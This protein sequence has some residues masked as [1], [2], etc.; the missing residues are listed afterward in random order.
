METLTYKLKYDALDIKTYFDTHNICFFDIETTGFNR[1]KDI[2]YLV[3]LLIYNGKDYI[4]K[5]YLLEEVDEEKILLNCLIKDFN[6]CECLI[7]FNGDSFDI[8]FLDSKYKNHHIDYKIPIEKSFDIYKIIKSNKYL[9]DLK[10]FKL[11]SIEKYLGINRK[12]T[13]SGKECIDLFYDYLDNKNDKSKKLILQHNYDDLYYL[14]YVLKIL[15]IIEYKKTIVLSSNSSNKIKLKI[16]DFK[17]ID[18][19]MN[20]N[21]ITNSIEIEPLII[22]ES[23]YNIKWNTKKGVL[24]VQFQVNNGMLSTMEKCLYIDLLEFDIGLSVKD[25]T[26]FQLP[27]NIILIQIGKDF[28]MDNIKNIVYQIVYTS[29]KTF[30]N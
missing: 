17:V 28:V 24:N 13:L 26:N 29:T 15:D 5:Q 10:N 16:E 1:N 25:S 22:Y 30:F 23:D 7:T 21:C 20:I 18:D 19:M 3:G 4:L 27:R 6:D 11:K 14:P 12:D 9:F 8:P 2:V